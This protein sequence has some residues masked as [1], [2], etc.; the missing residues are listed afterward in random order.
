MKMKVSKLI[1][2]KGRKS[3]AELIVRT[4]EFQNH[5]PWLKEGGRK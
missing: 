3:V 4:R 5:K 1:K 2:K